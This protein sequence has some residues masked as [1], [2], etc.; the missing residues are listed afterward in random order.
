MMSG[1]KI[2]RVF[3][4]LPQMIYIQNDGIIQQSLKP[5]VKFLVLICFDSNSSKLYA[6]DP[7]KER[8]T[9]P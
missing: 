2:F 6:K 4:S 5:D 8:Q 1:D 9:H 7:P 3:V